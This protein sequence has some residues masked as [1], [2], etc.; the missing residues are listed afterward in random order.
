[1]DRTLGSYE[2]WAAVMGGILTTAGI[3]GF[4]GNLSEFYEAA[5]IEGAIWRQFVAGWWETFEDQEV[6][7]GALFPIAAACDGFD[8][9]NAKTDH[10]QK[11]AFGK[12]L[13]SLRDRVVGEYRVTS[14]RQ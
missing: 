1:T 3:P 10:A 8:L 7:A 5:D 13:G 4:L 11:V 14:P 2:R 6:R 12:K 9:G